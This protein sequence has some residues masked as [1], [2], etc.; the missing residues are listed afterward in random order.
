[1]R[2]CL[3]LEEE[4]TL[5]DGM[6]ITPDGST[7]TMAEGATMDLGGAP[8]HAERLSEQEFKESMEDEE[9]RDDIQ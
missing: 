8:T 7:R 4:I 3:P 6:R 2:G 9:S 5:S 1:M